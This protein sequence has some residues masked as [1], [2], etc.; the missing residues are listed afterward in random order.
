[1]GAGFGN[2]MIFPAGEW[3]AGG[4]EE[5]M[6]NLSCDPT[7]RVGLCVEKMVGITHA[8]RNNG[9]RRQDELGT[10]QSVPPPDRPAIRRDRDGHCSWMVS[11]KR[12][13]VAQIGFGC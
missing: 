2:G 7:S 9:V 10:E 12:V 11:M 1:M 4:F 13:N 6:T 3:V 8:R 5:R